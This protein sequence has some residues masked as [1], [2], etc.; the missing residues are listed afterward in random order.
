M[1]LRA[2]VRRPQSL[3]VRDRLCP[4][5]SRNVPQVAVAAMG[6]DGRGSG[7]SEPDWA[8]AARA[9]GWLPPAEI[10]LKVWRARNLNRDSCR[11]C[12]ARRTAGTP[13]RPAQSHKPRCQFYDGPVA[14]AFMAG[15]FG[16][17]DYWVYCTC[18]ASY[19]EHDAEGNKQE[20]PDRDLAWRHPKTPDLL[21]DEIAATG[22]EGAA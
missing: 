21:A 19:P 8:P 3:Q 2:C 5:S 6:S 17:F 7:V 15:R 11:W 20:C 16:T 9:D 22:T 1:P 4:V 14:H 13:G 12:G 18:G 10:E